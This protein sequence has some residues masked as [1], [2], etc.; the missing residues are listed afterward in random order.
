MLSNE[1]PCESSD[2]PYSAE[3]EEDGT[4]PICNQQRGRK[5]R[6]QKKKKTKTTAELEGVKTHKTLC[7]ICQKNKKRIAPIRTAAGRKAILKSAKI[8]GSSEN[9]IQKLK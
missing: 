2:E 4:D 6:K 8:F 9:S 1:E 3:D 5:R 7:I